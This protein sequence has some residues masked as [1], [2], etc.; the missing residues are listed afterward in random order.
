MNERW[1]APGAMQHKW[2]T[3]LIRLEEIEGYS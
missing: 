2:E 1:I 3:D